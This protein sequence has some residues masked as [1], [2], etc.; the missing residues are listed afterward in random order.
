LTIS[1]EF[2]HELQAVFDLLTDPDFLVDRNLA[3]GEL[4]AEYEAEA[5]E[6]GATI[7]AVR[8][9]H[10]NLPGVLAKLF[11]PVN[12]MDMKENWRPSSD[13]WRGDWTMEVREQPITIY[14]DFELV[15]TDKGCRYSV[16]HRA[17]AKIP[18]L[19]G[20]VEKFTLGQTDKGAVDEQTYLRNYLDQA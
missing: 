5:S 14:G 20:Q 18:L 4:S 15:P 13:G 12:I 9:I 8:E 3:L 16:S 2:E 10:R 11:D 1:T 19:G 7:N 6:K 17:R